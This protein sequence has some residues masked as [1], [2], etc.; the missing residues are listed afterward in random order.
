VSEQRLVGRPAAPGFAL[1]PVA[2]LRREARARQPGTLAQEATALRT[3]IAQASAEVAALAAQ[4]DGDGADILAF[5]V[6]LLADEALCEP[7]LAAIVEGTPADVAW[8]AALDR[9]IADYAQADDHHFRARTADF[10]DLRDRVLAH[11]SGAAGVAT[12]TPPGAILVADDLTPS[13]FLAT[14]WTRGGAIALGAGSASSHVAVLARARGVP[15]VVGLGAVPRACREALV[16]GTRGLVAFDPSAALR[17]E[18]AQRA[19]TAAQQAAQEE[20]LRF[21]P[22]RMADGTPVTI[23]VNVA[24]PDELA[25]CDPAMCD[26]VGLVRTEF[27]FRSDGALPDEERQLAIY[28]RILD[29]A[30]GRPVTFRT[31]DAGGDKPIPGLTVDDEANPFLGV[32]GIRLS[33][34]RPAVFRMQLRALARAAAHGP[35][36]VML[37]MVTLPQEL[38]RA[39]AMLDEEVAALIAAG[40]AAKRPALGI[41]IEVPAAAL[42]AAQFPAAFYSIGSNDLV[43]YSL[44]AARDNGALAALAD[45][46]HPAVLELIARTVAAGRQSGAEVSL[47][48]DAAAEP[49]LIPKLLATGLRVLSVPPLAVARVKAAVAA[50]DPRA[51]A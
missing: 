39:A 50:F 49:A 43:Q 15:M 40:I 38:T 23:L 48:G 26:G 34:V 17:E 24:D 4:V 31:L 36:K 22:A 8:S 47:C 41:M 13:R 27:L 3:A 20:L 42:S 21:A 18:F 32:R 25:G 30:A 44:A 5:Q 29:W 1:G 35:A 2:V 37:P 11:L 16:D 6:S 9:E 10:I 28:R 46:A 19:A 12:A 33:L 14:D 45:A 51:K 7:A